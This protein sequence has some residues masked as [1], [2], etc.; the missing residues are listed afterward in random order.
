MRTMLCAKESG[1]RR[2]Q[3]IEAD[4]IAL[5]DTQCVEG[6]R[7]ASIPRASGI[8]SSRRLLVS[9]IHVRRPPDSRIYTKNTDNLQVVSIA[10]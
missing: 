5:S 7:G 4:S 8:L 6:P 2:R 10:R 3:T 1:R 9:G